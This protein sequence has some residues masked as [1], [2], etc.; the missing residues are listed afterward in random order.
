M[1]TQGEDFLGESISAN[2]WVKRD[3]LLGE[4]FVDGVVDETLVLVIVCFSA[5][6]VIAVLVV[7]WMA[8]WILYRNVER[9]GWTYVKGH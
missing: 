2:G 1:R 5:M 9:R 8:L 7:A 3:G 4:M 6:K